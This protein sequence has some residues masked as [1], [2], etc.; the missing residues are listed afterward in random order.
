MCYF[1]RFAG[2]NLLIF[3]GYQTWDKDLF[4]NGQIIYY[5][6]NIISVIRKRIKL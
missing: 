6:V 3:S 1:C 2:A 4:N 5:P